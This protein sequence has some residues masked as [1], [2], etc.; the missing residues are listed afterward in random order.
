[1]EIQEIINQ[2]DL[3][4]TS[5][6]WQITSTLIFILTDVIV[7][8]ICAIIRKDLDSKKMR[9]GL[10]RKMLLVII[11]ALSFVIQ[12]AFFDMPLISKVVCGYIIIMEIISILE[13][14]KSAGCDLGKL[15]DL[16]KIDNKEE[17]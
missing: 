14:M 7:G 4:F 15:G 17:K 10:L 13:N 16:L 9:E 3:N 1:M 8:V 5:L 2:I 11:I 6:F 12:N